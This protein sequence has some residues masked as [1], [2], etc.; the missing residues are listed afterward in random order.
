MPPTPSMQL[1][2]LRWIWNTGPL[3]PDIRMVLCSPT[4]GW[5][6]CSRSL[7]TLL[8]QLG[9]RWSCNLAARAPPLGPC[10]V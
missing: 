2:L 5:F 9:V 6:T 3:F 8:G 4:S 10:R 1:K 7:V